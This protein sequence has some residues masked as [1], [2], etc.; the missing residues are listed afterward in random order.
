MYQ[1]GNSFGL[2]QFGLTPITRTKQDTQFLKSV[3]KGLKVLKV[4]KALKGMMAL[5]ETVGSKGLEVY[6]ANVVRKGYK[7]QKATKVSRALRVLT[8]EHSTPI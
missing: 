5:K 2:R 4:N 6:R 8:V 7:V 3:S 1:R